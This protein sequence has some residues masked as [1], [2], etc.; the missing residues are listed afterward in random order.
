MTGFDW[1]RKT[2]DGS[3]VVGEVIAK[4]DAPEPDAIQWLLLRVEGQRPTDEDQGRNGAEN[5][6]R[7]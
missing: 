7:R 2:N 1:A 6:L 4:A 5:G 3:A